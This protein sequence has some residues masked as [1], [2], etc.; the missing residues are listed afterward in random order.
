MIY[1]AQIKAVVFSQCISA[2]ERFS[3]TWGKCCV[4][5][6]VSAKLLTRAQHENAIIQNRFLVVI[7]WLIEN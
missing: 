4:K 1:I 7:A 6:S 5:G 3:C 2:F